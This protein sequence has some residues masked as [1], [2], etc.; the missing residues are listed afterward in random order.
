MVTDD[1]LQEFVIRMREAAESN[2]ES[3]ILFGSAVAGEF[4]PDFSNYNVFCVLRDTG[5]SALQKI[6]PAVKW[7]EGKKQPTPLFMTR[8][9]VSASSDVF[10]IEFYDMLQ[11]HHVLYGE[12][13]LTGVN[14]SLENHRTQ[15]E[16]ELRE[17]FIVLR[18]EVLHSF[19]SDK[20]L[21][22]LLVRSVAAFGTLF[23]HSVIAL[24]G[25]PPVSKRDAVHALARRIGFD[26]AAIDQILDVRERKVD[27]ASI[28]VK[29]LCS[30]YLAVIQQVTNAVD[31][32]IA[33]EGSGSK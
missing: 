24:G 14:V 3:V 31:R 30:R 21:W 2:L 10:A 9:E 4:H 26:P 16:Y 20:R 8:A 23:R 29:E 28:N 22:E 6:A 7:W 17:K 33:S 12:D 5:F 11:H 19:E 1:K 32:A 15:V 18:R 25:E 13:V 27:A